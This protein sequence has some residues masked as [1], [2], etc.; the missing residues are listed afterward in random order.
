M[1]DDLV[2]IIYRVTREL[3]VEERY[4]LQ[5]QIRRAAVSAA[6]NLVEGAARRSQREYAQSSEQP[7]APP[8][9]YGICSAWLVGSS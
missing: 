4:G 6:N 1:A 7:W 2:L 9:R 3:P 8:P 5:S